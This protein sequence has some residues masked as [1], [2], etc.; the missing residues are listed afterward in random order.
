MENTFASFVNDLDELR[1]FFAEHNFDRIDLEHIKRPGYNGVID[2]FKNE[3]QRMEISVLVNY[4]DDA[5]MYECYYQPNPVDNLNI[6]CQVFYSVDNV[7]KWVNS[8]L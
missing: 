4:K 5:P 7:I 3:V 6:E 2:S 8:K 1:K